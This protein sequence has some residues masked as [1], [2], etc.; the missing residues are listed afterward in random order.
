MTAEAL[1]WTLAALLFVAVLT[2]W[3]LHWIWCLMSRAVSSDRSRIADL[4]AR[5]DAAEHARTEAERAMEEANRTLGARIAE[6]EAALTAQ[7]EAHEAEL[8]SHAAEQA[9]LVESATREAEA[10]WDGL[11]NARRRIAELERALSEGG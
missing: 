9:R 1:S 6:L 2:G 3:L 10:A 11:G 5:L 7:A 4:T 8:A